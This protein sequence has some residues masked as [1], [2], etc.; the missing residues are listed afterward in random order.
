VIN[1]SRKQL[2]RYTTRESFS[3]IKGSIRAFEGAPN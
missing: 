2:I 3:V 1:P